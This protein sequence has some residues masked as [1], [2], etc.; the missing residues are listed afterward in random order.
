MAAYCLFLPSFT[1]PDTLNQSILALKGSDPGY[2][3]ECVHIGS[4]N[5]IVEIYTVLIERDSP[6]QRFVL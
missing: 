6:P 5:P 4:T 3:P 2:D 1:D